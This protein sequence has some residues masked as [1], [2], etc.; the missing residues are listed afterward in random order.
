ML[1]PAP[2]LVDVGR[3][4]S[5]Y[6]FLGELGGTIPKTQPFFLK[7]SYSTLRI[8]R[9]QSSITIQGLMDNVNVRRARCVCCNL[10]F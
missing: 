9:C 10:Q 5:L 2:V 8:I 3:G 7:C 4:D 6:L 1:L